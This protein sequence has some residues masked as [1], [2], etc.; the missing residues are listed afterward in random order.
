VG[1]PTLDVQEG[2][3][4]SYPADRWL[5][6]ASRTRRSRKR[7]DLSVS[8][9]ADRWL[10]APLFHLAL[11]GSLQ[12]FS[13]LSCGSLV[14]SLLAL[15][16]LQAGF[17]TFSILSCGSLVARLRAGDQWHED[18]VLFQYPILRIVGCN[19]DGAADYAPV[20]HSFSILS[21]GSLVARLPLLL[22]YDRPG[23]H[24]Q[25]PILRIVGCKLF[26]IVR[27]RSDRPRFQY[28]ILRIVGCKSCFRG[29]PKE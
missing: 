27:L 8:Y 11:L 16:N 26:S 28:P 18:A 12:A 22:A 19:S 14:A 25:Y 10:Q 17:Q 2:L 9:P 15:S 20:V 3:S 13:I 5:Q 21:C 1:G 24:F 7:R 6:E 4:V 23:E 29:V